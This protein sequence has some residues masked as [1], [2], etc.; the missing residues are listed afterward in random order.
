MVRNRRRTIYAVLGITLAVS[1]IAGSLIAVDSASVGLIRE[2]LEDIPVDYYGQSYVYLQ[3]VDTERY[4]GVTDNL[5]EVA[6]VEQAS[7]VLSVGGWAFYNVEGSRYYN[8]YD[9]YQTSSVMLIP[10]DPSVLMER[11]QIYGEAPAPGTVAVPHNVAAFLD[12]EAGDEI[13]CGYEFYEYNSSD[14]TSILRYANMSLEVSQVW[15]QAE[16]VEEMWQWWYWGEEVVDDITFIESRN[17]VVMYISDSDVMTEAF[18]E[19]SFPGF[20]ERYT[21][22]IDRDD[23]VRLTNIALTIESLETLN[24]RLERAAREVDAR[25]YTPLT[26]VLYEMGDDMTQKKLVFVALSLP[27]MA[28]GIY[29]SLVGVEMGMTERRREVGVLK[30]RGASN[31]QVFA[32]MISESL[33]LGALASLLGLGLGF[34]LSRFLVVAVS[35]MS[36]TGTAEPDLATFFVSTWTVVVVV[37]FGVLLMLLSSYG[38]MRR[39][40]RMP[41][42][43]ALHHYTPKTVKVGYKARYDIAAL[44]LCGLS[45]ASVF[46]LTDMLS[47]WRSASLMTYFVI[48]VVVSVGWALVPAVPFLLSVSVIR[49]VTR[50][51]RRL[52]TRFSWLVKSWTKELHYIVE[53]NIARNP[54]RASNVGIIVSLAVAFGLFVSVTMESELAYAEDVVMYEVGADL[55]YW[56]YALYAEGGPSEIDFSAMDSVDTVEGVGSAAMYLNV[57]TQVD[58]TY[59]SVA[60]FDS[61]E[62]TDVVDV[63]S[64]WYA[65]DGSE[66]IRDLKENGTAFISEGFADNNYLVVGDSL[67]VEMELNTG[68]AN[69]SGERTVFW[70]DV[71][72]LVSQLPGLSCDVYVDLDTL[73]F[74]DMGWY[75]DYSVGVGV[76]VDVEDGADHSETADRLRTFCYAANLDG[77]VEVAQERIDEVTSTPEFK[78]I[79]DF[80]YLEYALSLVM[81]T[82]GVGLVLFVTVWDRRQELACIMA[83]GSSPEQMRRIL[84]G[85]SLSLMALGMVVGVSAGVLSA[86]LYNA[87]VYGV[88]SSE[89]PHLTVFSWVSWAVVLSAVASFVIASYLATF[90][91]GK[92]KLAEILRIRGG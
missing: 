71:I 8:E 39:A 76:F 59:A 24:G 15:S 31:R 49:L 4:D 63:G 46:G 52:Y 7:C 83:R 41:V 91:L 20:T 72:G 62:L 73:S 56:G 38:P 22:W 85:E 21:V 92:L 84:M 54:K 16:D 88:S 42:A 48:A 66:D 65:G 44:I 19:G 13:I 30:S 75:P 3:D 58:Y 79:R 45:A 18:P 89:V 23:Y 28:M 69:F 60:L 35:G 27:V 53:K 36:S 82:C 40:A 9:W 74:I 87:L 6:G 90:N 51:S 11:Y 2:R 33:L 32:S 25:F 68:D 61:E 26:S 55:R 34:V 77:Q 43:E 81:L 64:G 78:S 10:D 12:I 5:L 1:L 47:T 14:G 70:L 86:I 80:L 57:W 50:G 67:R 17:P 29:L 37:I